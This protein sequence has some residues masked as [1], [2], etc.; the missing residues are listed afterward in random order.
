M[1]WNTIL[2]ACFRPATTLLV[3]GFAYVYMFQ[4]G[5]IPF[6]TRKDF[7]SIVTNM[8]L[9][10]TIFCNFT[11]KMSFEEFQ[12]S[13]VIMIFFLLSMISGALFSFLVRSVVPF[14]DQFRN[15]FTMMCMFPDHIVNPLIAT[16]AIC[17]TTDLWTIDECNAR[18]TSIIW[19]QAPLFYG[20]MTIV[21][22]KNF[23]PN[24]QFH[25]LLTNP[26][27]LASAFGLLF[28]MI[29]PLSEFVKTNIWM[30]DFYGP[31]K[32][33]ASMA[34]PL[35]LFLSYGKLAQNIIDIC[36]FPGANL[37]ENPTT[38]D[39]RMANSLFEKFS[40]GDSG[41]EDSSRSRSPSRSEKES[42][43]SQEQRDTKN[44]SNESQEA[45]KEEFCKG[46]EENKEIKSVST[47]DKI[48][49]Y[50]I[51]IA[52]GSLLIFGLIKFATVWFAFDGDK[53]VKIVMLAASIMPTAVTLIVM[54]L[55]HDE[56]S[57]SSILFSVCMHVMI[58]IIIVSAAIILIS[59]LILT[60]D[61]T[62]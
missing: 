42:I 55:K 15:V 13:Y 43:R 14:S 41:S 35:I 22:E 38:H 40:R 4:R 33:I 26:I 34:V 36:A 23:D 27:I 45:N 51:L 32:I 5:F 9:P 39:E 30:N 52:F 29:S 44:G 37:N 11:E 21:V 7:G 18:F 62:A 59:E 46:D 47:E 17:R 2:A 16:D 19:L 50:D 58:N 20:G 1:D 25:T 8:L 49:T 6:Q 57:A 60:E 10:M 54:V 12:S 31:F 53:Q 48:G 56:E 24:F 3:Y 61:E 28:G